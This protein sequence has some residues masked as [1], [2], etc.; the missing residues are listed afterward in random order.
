MPSRGRRLRTVVRWL[1]AASIGAALK[2][3]RATLYRLFEPHG[4][5]AS[6]LRERRLLRI[7]ATLCAPGPRRSLA[8]IA[9]DHGFQ[10]AAQFSRAFRAQFGYSPSEAASAG[11]PLD[12]AP[13][14][15]TEPPRAESLAAWLRPLQR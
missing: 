15:A 5:V 3:S 7:H 8:A 10:S 11:Q 4:G 13:A 6:Y 12:A 2:V 14:A 1:G 9:E